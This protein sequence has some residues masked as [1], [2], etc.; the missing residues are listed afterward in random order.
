[1]NQYDLFDAMNGIDDELL[2]RSEQRAAKKLPLRRALIAAAAVMLLAATAV[3]TPGIRDWI[4][5]SEAEQVRDSTVREYEDGRKGWTPATFSGK[6]EVPNA[7]D[8]PEGI[9]EYRMPAYFV[10]NGWTVIPAILIPDEPIYAAHFSYH[11]PMNAN[12]WASFEQD[13]LYSS[14][15][16]ETTKY[17]NYM[18]DGG[19]DGVVEEIPVTIGDWTATLYITPPS[20]VEGEF[21]LPGRQKIVWTDGEYAYELETNYGFPQETIEEII[22][23]LAPYDVSVYGTVDPSADDKMK[24]IEVFYSLTKQPEGYKLWMRNWHVNMTL[25]YWRN[26]SGDMVTLSQSCK[27]GPDNDGPAISIEDTIYMLE[28][29]REEFTTEI[30]YVDGLKVTLIRKANGGPQLMWENGEYVFSIDFTS[31]LGLTSEELMEYVQSVQVMEDFT[32]HLTS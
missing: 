6:L 29:D 20:E 14:A 23:S 17:Y 3:A 15:S 10:E 5:A 7:G 19:M 27:L 30:V 32:D 16:W 8:A 1:M 28:S 25:E 11:D 24:P 9:E 2:A 4:F 12:N 21:Y 18:I 26:G 22:L 31:D 13:C